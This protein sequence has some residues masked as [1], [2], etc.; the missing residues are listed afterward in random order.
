MPF[1]GSPSVLGVLQHSTTPPLHHSIVSRN[2]E[3]NRPG[4]SPLLFEG[5][6]GEGAQPCERQ[7]TMKT[8]AFIPLLAMA[9]LST[10]TTFYVAQLREAS[11]QLVAPEP[12]EGG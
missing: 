4:I 6:G 12:G 9:H 7:S 3:A 1:Q 10:I 8:E 2:R 11:R 5:P